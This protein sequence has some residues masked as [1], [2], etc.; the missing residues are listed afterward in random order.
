MNVRPVATTATNR[1]ETVARVTK[2]RPSTTTIDSVVRATETRV[3]PRPKR[4]LA[5]GVKIH[6]NALRVVATKTIGRHRRATITHR[7]TTRKA[8]DADRD[9]GSVPC[10]DVNAPTRS[11]QLP[12]RAGSRSVARRAPRLNPTD[13]T[14]PSLT[15]DLEKLKNV[16]VA[17]TNGAHPVRMFARPERRAVTA[18]SRLGVEPRRLVL[19]AR[20]KVAG[21]PIQDARRATAAIVTT[22]TQKKH[23]GR[24]L[25]RRSVRIN[26]GSLSTG[27]MGRHHGDRSP[28]VSISALRPTGGTAPKNAPSCKHA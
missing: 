16:V 28:N 5:G 8:I 19:A 2:R 15:S 7:P 25:R 1:A 27:S 9:E 14:K 24:P 20:T 12:R 3:V 11:G 21:G 4:D 10:R 13:A 18:V 26:N 17:N 23:G 6:T 22:Y